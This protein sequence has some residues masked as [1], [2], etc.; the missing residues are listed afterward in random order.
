VAL[1]TLFLLPVMQLYDDGSAED[2]EHKA[3]SCD[4]QRDQN[5]VLHDEPCSDEATGSDV[6]DNEDDPKPREHAPPLTK[7]ATAVQNSAAT[8]RC[9]S[10]VSCEALG[11]VS[12][13][14]QH[15]A[16]SCT[17]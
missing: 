2:A 3:E 7:H 8:G 14:T 5:I 16:F 12:T 15:A 9:Q 17:E 1:D 13:D 11:M 4:N 6:D 10:G